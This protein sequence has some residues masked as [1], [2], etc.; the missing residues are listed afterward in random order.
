MAAVAVTPS[1]TGPSPPDDITTL[2]YDDTERPGDTR[3]STTFKGTRGHTR[4][5]SISGSNSR[6]SAA[7]TRPAR[8]PALSP[9]DKDARIYAIRIFF[10]IAT[11]MVSGVLGFAVAASTFALIALWCVRTPHRWR[12]GS[13]RLSHPLRPATGSGTRCFGRVVPGPLEDSLCLWLS[14]RSSPSFPRR[15]WARASAAQRP[16]LTPPQTVFNCWEIRGAGVGRVSAFLVHDD[17]EQ[18]RG[19]L[20]DGVVLAARRAVS[21][22]VASSHCG[23]WCVDSRP[24]GLAAPAR[25]VGAAQI[26][27]SVALLF[28]TSA[29]LRQGQHGPAFAR[30][31]A[32]PAELCCA[33]CGAGLYGPFI[34]IGAMIGQQ[35][36]R[37]YERRLMLWFPSESAAG[38]CS[39]W[40]RCEFRALG[41]RTYAP[42]LVTS[43]EHRA[44]IV[45]GSVSPAMQPAR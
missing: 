7:T 13:H 28:S 2:A 1:E 9:A 36:A 45:M 38:P 33:L 32:Q 41:L 23:S 19:A 14:Q 8:R 3:T 35:M 16:V 39:L 30:F 20:A 4:A 34:H 5:V 40:L 42:A 43:V 22:P 29:Q 44:L 11:G 26:K 37:F 12:T 6:K 10:S 17:C 24:A 18:G 25:P 21:T 27:K 31:A 15:W